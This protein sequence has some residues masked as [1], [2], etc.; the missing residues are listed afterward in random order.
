VAFLPC[1]LAVVAYLAAYFSFRAYHPSAYDGNRLS[2]DLPHIFMTWLYATVSPVPGW[3]FLRSND[4]TFDCPFLCSKLIGFA[5]S[6]PFY[7]AK[8]IF[9]ALKR[10]GPA[11]GETGA[12]R[13]RE[14]SS[15]CS[16]GGL[17][18]WSIHAKFAGFAHYQT[19]A[20]G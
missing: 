15:D 17:S 11:R 6:Q 7:A 13:K 5:C 2:F 8:A 10:T 19:S 18:N 16:S 3:N 4:F 1:G 20:D 9:A 12:E 14:I